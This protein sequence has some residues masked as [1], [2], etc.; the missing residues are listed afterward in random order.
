[1]FDCQNSC[2][3]PQSCC[4]EVFETWQ[5]EGSLNDGGIPKVT[6]A[7]EVNSWTLK[8]DWVPSMEHFT[9]SVLMIPPL[10]NCLWLISNGKNTQWK[11][12]FLACMQATEGV[13]NVKVYISEGAA[14]VEVIFSTTRVA[15]KPY[16]RWPLLGGCSH[17]ISVI[18]TCNSLELPKC[19]S[20]FQ[21]IG[22]YS[23]ISESTLLICFL[24][25]SYWNC[26]PPPKAW[27]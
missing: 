10:K 5:A 6:K 14:T 9:G 23:E 4:S 20:Q 27:S 8:S 25:Y 13:S 2:F 16:L 3:Y 19:Y 12:T 15:E 21:M 26:V 11:L 24:G 7:L 1:M 18:W 22:S 17:S